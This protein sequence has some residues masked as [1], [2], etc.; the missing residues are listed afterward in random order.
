MNTP[1]ATRIRTP[2]EIALRAGVDFPRLLPPGRQ[3]FAERA[4]RLRQLAAGHAM[5]DYLLLMALVCEA[6][7][8]RLPQHP[9]V[10]LPSAA[11]MDAAAQSGQP[12][13]DARHWPRHPAWRTEL[14]ALLAQVLQ[15]LPEGSPARAG[16]QAVQ[17]MADDALEQQAGRL[18]A[19]ITLGLDMAAAPLI[20]AGLQLHWVHLVG[21]TSAAQKNPSPF[22]MAQDATRCPCCGSLPTA[23]ITRIGGGQDGYRYLHCTLCSAQW[24]MVRVKCTH[25]QGTAGI[26]YQS[27]QALADTES[28][29]R[30]EAVQAE[31]CDSCGHYLKIVHMDRDQHVEPVADDLATLTLDL[32]VS[33]A[34]FQRHGTN[35]LLLFGD[36]EAPAGD[37]APPERG[38]A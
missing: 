32:L 1:T 36:S 3:V 16:V 9:A 29:A 5:R 25:C 18:L 37:G 26:H 27:L 20:A 8:Q 12:L 31:T 23:S 24:H 4:L 10:P 7:H 21:A 19:G 33:D 14:R 13:L 35:L 28:A 15:K 17:G 11:Q 22:G 38:P 30:R 6:Q 2:E 34:G